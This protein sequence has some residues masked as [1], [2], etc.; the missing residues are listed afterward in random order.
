MPEAIF[1]NNVVIEMD[2]D[3]NFI[4]ILCGTDCTFSRTPEF[5][6]VTSSGSGLFREFLQRREEWAMSVSGLTKI[7]NAAT[8]T[9]FLYAPNLS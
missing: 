9:F 1:G 8:L 4:E 6:P 7:E 2:V 5:I 3:G